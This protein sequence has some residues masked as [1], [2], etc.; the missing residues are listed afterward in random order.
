MKKKEFISL[1]SSH[2]S[3]LPPEEQS[4]LL[5]DYESHFAF[6]LQNGRTEE[7]IVRE[8]GDP[9]ELAQE[10]LANRVNP[11]HPLYWFGEPPEGQT[12]TSLAP[13]AQTSSRHQ[14][15]TSAIYTGLFFLNL[16]ILPLLAA[17]WALGLAIALTAMAGILSP[18]ALLLEYIF[19]N[20]FQPTKAFAVLAMVGIGI[21]IAVGTRHLYSNLI[22]LSASYWAWNVR[23]A[24]GD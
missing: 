22:K 3:A 13:A 1:L 10:A 7:E 2:L 11:L 14:M 4:E 6:G 15:I 5:E 19:N 9:A 17:L 23:V 16:V 18:A 24:K 20:V 8:L 21:L 12:S